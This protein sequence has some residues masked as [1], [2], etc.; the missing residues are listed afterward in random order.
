MHGDERKF[1]ATE[2]TSYRFERL[3][4]SNFAKRK[5]PRACF[6]RTTRSSI[7]KS[8]SERSAESAESAGYRAT[9]RTEQGRFSPVNFLYEPSF[10]FPSRAAFADN[11]PIIALA[12]RR[13]GIRR[14][15]RTLEILPR[16]RRIRKNEKKRCGNFRGGELA[17]V[18][19]G[20]TVFVSNSS[21][22]KPR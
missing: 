16:E 22:S 21:R 2:T 19:R 14:R 5:T 20:D 13:S 7:S 6:H 11:D 17:S 12:T 3:V 9:T 15:R 8:I 1:R 18:R 4:E 10:S